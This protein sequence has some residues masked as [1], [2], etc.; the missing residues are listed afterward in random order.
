MMIQV[1]F[2]CLQVPADSA[3]KS[4]VPALCLFFLLLN[5]CKNKLQYGNC[6][7]QFFFVLCY[8]CIFRQLSL[9]VQKYKI[10]F[11]VDI[12]DRVL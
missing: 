10:I 5:T 8:F 1:P 7:R 2:C 12:D 6:F 9:S 4:T 3:L 11:K